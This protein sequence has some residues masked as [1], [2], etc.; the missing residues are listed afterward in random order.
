MSPAGTRQEERTHTYLS[1]I[2][3]SF[4]RSTRPRSART[5]MTDLERG[6]TRSIVALSATVSAWSDTV[7]EAS[8]LSPSEPVARRQRPALE[9]SAR[10]SRPMGRY[11]RY[12]K[13]SIAGALTQDWGARWLCSGARGAWTSGDEGVPTSA[14]V[15]AGRTLASRR[16][17]GLFR[18]RAAAC[19]GR[20]RWG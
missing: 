20:G 9:S 19:S 10:R 14:L 6:H 13:A 15:V 12:C 18:V 8:P 17:G 7:C 16:R 4:A 2:S 11:Y 3:D 5:R 1:G